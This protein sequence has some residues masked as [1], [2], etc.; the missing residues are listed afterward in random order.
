M[1]AKTIQSVKQDSP[2][3][4]KQLEGRTLIRM[5]KHRI[6]LP[7]HKY[8]RIYLSKKRTRLLKENTLKSWDYTFE[9]TYWYTYH[10]P[11]KIKQYIDTHREPIPEKI[12]RVINQ[13]VI[14]HTK[15]PWWKRLFS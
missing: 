8:K 13:Q 12:Q 6:I 11:K 1:I 3:W 7:D 2:E 4:I 14:Q 9:D 10:T 15:K 5:G